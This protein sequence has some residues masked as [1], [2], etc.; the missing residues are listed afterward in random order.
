MRF[1]A[2]LTLKSRLVAWRQEKAAQHNAATLYLPLLLQ[3]PLK[4]T[5]Y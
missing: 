2:A 4:L 1:C 5:G 3:L